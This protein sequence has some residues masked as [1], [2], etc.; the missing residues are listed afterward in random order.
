MRDERV[1]Y[2]WGPKKDTPV[3]Y[4][5]VLKTLFMPVTCVNSVHSPMQ[6]SDWLCGDGDGDALFIC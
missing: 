2:P 6:L 5:Y 1:M 4:Q 3:N